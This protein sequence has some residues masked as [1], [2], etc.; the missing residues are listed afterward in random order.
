MPLVQIGSN[1]FNFTENR[2]KSVLLS[3]LPFPKRNNRR[4]L[5]F[6]FPLE[7]DAATLATDIIS[8]HATWLQQIGQV[9]GLA[10]DDE[11]TLKV[12][13]RLQASVLRQLHA[14]LLV[15]QVAHQALA[16]GSPR[17]QDTVVLTQVR[18]YVEMTAE[19][20]V[21]DQCF[22]TAGGRCAKKQHSQYSR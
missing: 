8:G 6:L 19:H 20:R 5:A 10:L 2:K 11:T 14:E 12:V 16:V 18:A 9:E 4:I 22:L 17:Q 15:A 21:A 13:D 3:F 7:A 1:W